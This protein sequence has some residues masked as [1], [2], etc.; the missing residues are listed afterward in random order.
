MKT[1]NENEGIQVQSVTACYLCGTEEGSI[2][3]NSLRDRLFGAPGNWNLRKCRNPECKLIW[4]D[5]MP[6]QTD[7]P[8]IY[9]TYYTHQ[10]SISSTYSVKVQGI[11]LRPFRLML[12]EAYQ[13][14]LYLT[15]MRET[16]PKARLDLDT[17]Y[18]ANNKPGRL[19]DVGCGNGIF[20]DCMRSRGWN[21]QGAEVDRKS[22]LIAKRT[23]GIPV[24]IGTLEEAKYPNGYFDAITLN[25]VI[26]HVYDPIGLLKEC[27]RILKPG[28]FIVA[29]TPNV[30][31]IGHTR[32]ERNW[33]ALDPPRHFHL[34]SRSTIESIASKAGFQTMEI[35]TTPVHA[36]WHAFA[37]LDVQ[38]TG[39]HDK[40]VLPS[41]SREVLSKWF[42]LLALRFYRK[43]PDSG[44]ELVL[45]ASK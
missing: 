1:L 30:K 12:K 9:E 14:L 21:V 2:L 13:L 29:V 15:T 19:L 45:K 36:E 10:V 39:Y 32:F 7:I 33:I 25:H 44:E 41:F 11:L 4:L 8:K 16:L 18:L 24:H 42:Q 34:F 3:Y 26:E 23:F 6:T 5:P 35:W 38:S 20:L 43:Q 17:M 22:A 28:G 27:Y 31:S 40:R 37:S